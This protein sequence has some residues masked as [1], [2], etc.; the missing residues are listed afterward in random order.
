MYILWDD[1]YFTTLHLSAISFT[2]LILTELLMVAFEV[3]TWHWFM[4]AA[5]VCSESFSG[6]IPIRRKGRMEGDRMV[7]RKIVRCGGFQLRDFLLLLFFGFVMYRK[8][9]LR[10][11]RRFFC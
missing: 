11:F 9:C 4:V 10:T 3:H 7:E 5:E 2:A 6:E 8:V 1:H